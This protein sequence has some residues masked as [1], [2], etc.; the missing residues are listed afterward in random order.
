[1]VI[2]P[3]WYL[4]VELRSDSCCDDDRAAVESDS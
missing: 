1:M 2:R 4:K 3:D